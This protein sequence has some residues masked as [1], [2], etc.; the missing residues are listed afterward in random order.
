[1]IDML[2]TILLAL[3]IIVISLWIFVVLYYLGYYISLGH[4]PSTYTHHGIPFIT[5]HQRRREE[6]FVERLTKRRKGEKWRDYRKRRKYGSEI[7]EYLRGD[8]VEE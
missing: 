8:D 5:P 6:K 2:R 1:M 7:R 4:F 3:W